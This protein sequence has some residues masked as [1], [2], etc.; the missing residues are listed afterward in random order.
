MAVMW[1]TYFHSGGLYLQLIHYE[2][3]ICKYCLRAYYFYC[4]VTAGA[5]DGDDAAVAVSLVMY[6]YRLC[7]LS[8]E[9]CLTLKML[10]LTNK[11]KENQVFGVFGY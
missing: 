11:K 1:P 6:I 9:L 3:W 4:D 2:F 7:S 10:Y 5:H 8:W